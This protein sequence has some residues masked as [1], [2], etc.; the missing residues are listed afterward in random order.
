MNPEEK[1]DAEASENI[2]K[3]SKKK[4]LFVDLD[5]EITALFERIETLP[6]KE[7]YLVVP[8]RATLLQSVVNL[9]ILKQKL[10]D[11]DKELAIVTSDTNGMKLA[12]QAEIKIFDHWDLK[13]AEGSK[14]KEE[15]SESTL[16]KPI[17]ANSNEIEE[18][19]PSR[20]PQ[21]KASIFEVVR[22]LR[23]KEKG[24]SLGSYLRD[25]RKNRLNQDNFGFQFSSPNRKWVMSLFGVSAL[26]FF[27]IAYVVLPG[28]TISI[29]PASE[30]ITKGV[31]VN[32][33]KSPSGDRDLKSYGVSTEVE[34]TVSHSASGIVSE[35]SRAGGELTIINTS[36]QE[37]ALV[38][39]TRF[40]TEEGLI[41]R[42]Q[43][44][45]T[46]PSGS[47]E[48]PGKL[49]ARVL[50]DEVDANGSP[51][52]ERGNIGPSRFFLPGL[53][54]SSRS[55]LYAESLTDM[56]GGE[57]KVRTFVVEEDMIAAKEQITLQLKEKVLSSLRK[58]VLSLSN[59]EGLDLVLLED[60]DVLQY[61][62]VSV[63]LPIEL[64]GK[65]Q[66]DFDVTGTLTLKGVAYDEDALLEL[67][68]V[69]VLNSQTPGKQIIK[70]NEDSISIN[71]LEFDNSTLS[72]K[73]T[74]EIQA[75]E[76]YQI[77]PDL[78]GGST[79]SKKIKEH[80]AGQSIEEA[81][82]YIQNLPEVNSV[83]IKV[84]PAWSPKIPTLSD[85][86]RIKSLSTGEPL[87]LDSDSL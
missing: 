10:A 36:G 31:N 52:G 32:L 1:N 20:L 53:K 13:T 56:V 48:T 66:E 51:I 82:Q 22:T 81:E 69:E 62:E 46:V 86:I 67:L 27:I 28:A 21:K 11:I 54:E 85:N 72:Y 84:W 47:V 29:E 50:A 44:S 83:E 63:D 2:K 57:T 80:I 19:N 24:F 26:V 16:L 30:V 35:G 15:K 33:E 41:F 78:E 9:K 45:V 49:T 42:L 12:Q 71:V 58:E 76:E 75:V 8:K 74:A 37:W 43:S 17:A 68:K 65:E 23:G 38:K 79:L 18:E 3:V 87:V 61:G 14:K 60:A 55:T 7:V 34:L 59:Q 70:L 5:E 4:I 64:I 25:W 40:Q 77:D 6:Y 73:F 39:D